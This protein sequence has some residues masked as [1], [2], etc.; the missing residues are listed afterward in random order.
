LLK[1]SKGKFTKNLK[2]TN[3]LLIAKYA[4]YTQSTQTFFV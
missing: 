3:I 4:K 2:Y 1:Y